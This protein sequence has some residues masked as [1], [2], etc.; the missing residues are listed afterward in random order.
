MFEYYVKCKFC[1]KT[2]RL[3]VV[4]I[5]CKYTCGFCKNI[6]DLSYFEEVIL[7]ENIQVIEDGRVSLP[8]GASETGPAITGVF[9]PRNP[10]HLFGVLLS[11]S[12]V[13]YLFSLSGN[14]NQLNT[15]M[16]T[17]ERRNNEG[18]SSEAPNNVVSEQNNNLFN[19]LIISV[20]NFRSKKEWKQMSERE[21]NEC[22][23]KIFQLMKDNNLSKDEFWKNFGEAIESDFKK[24][25]SRSGNK[26][27]L[28]RSAC[29]FTIK[30]SDDG[31]FYLIKMTETES[32][33]VIFMFFQGGKTFSTKVPPGNYSFKYG[34]G[35]KWYGWVFLFG[36]SNNFVKSNEELSFYVQSEEDGIRYIGHTIELIKQVGGNFRTRPIDEDEF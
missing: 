8:V 21:K 7:P 2:N 23:M 33:Q 5:S 22:W 13:W 32:Q 29:P 1:E 36:P 12:F 35:E 17:L 26:S 27:F 10:Y 25:R 15:N 4:D 34:Y 9:N 18:H 6:L 31:D 14:N 3:S 11:F 24:P 30:T 28:S 20:R 16:E 19:D